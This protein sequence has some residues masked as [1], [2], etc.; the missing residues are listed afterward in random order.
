MLE[1]MQVSTPRVGKHPSSIWGLNAAGALK[2]EAFHP[3]NS[4]AVLLLSEIEHFGSF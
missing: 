2:G 1:K 4:E 3:G